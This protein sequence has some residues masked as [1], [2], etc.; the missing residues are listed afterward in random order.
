MEHGADPDT[1]ITSGYD[2][3]QAPSPNGYGAS[4]SE[5]PGDA[6]MAVGIAFVAGFL[7]GGL[8]SRLGS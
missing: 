1:Q 3:T 6:L 8:V 5:P 4:V 2:A 7:L